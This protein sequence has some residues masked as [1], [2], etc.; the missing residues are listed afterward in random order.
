VCV[1]CGG[2]DPKIKC[3]ARVSKRMERRT[4]E[5]NR[6][7]QGKGEEEE[8]GKTLTC[9]FVQIPRTPVSCTTNK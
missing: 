1:F 6:G 7:K 3:E 9:H 5:G 4:G 2:I 8:G